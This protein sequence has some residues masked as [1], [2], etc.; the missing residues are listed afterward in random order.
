MD[1]AFEPVEL[2]L[3]DPFTIA[4][5]TQVLAETVHLT[6]TQDDSSGIGEA[7][8][9]PHYGELGSTVL[10][11]LAALNDRLA[12][13]DAPLSISAL[14]ALMD[15]VAMLNPAAKAAVD[16]A[17]YDLLGKR[18]G[19]PVYEILGLDP[20][21]AP[22]TSYTIG[23]DTP[24]VMA[25]K[26]VEAGSYPVLKV[27]VGT[28]NDEANLKAIRAERPDALIRVDANMAWKPKEAVEKIER[29]AEYDL[30][31]IEQPVHGHDLEGLGYVRSA[32]SL[33]VIADESCIAPSDVAKVAPYVDGINIKLMKCGGIYPAL[34]MIHIARGLGLSVMMGCMIESSLA[35]TAAAHLSPLI[36]YAD[37]DGHL[38]IDDD[39][40]RGVL[41]EDG[42]LVLGQSPGLGVEQAR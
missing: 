4:R 31:F 38:L 10:V 15:D 20:L 29:L 26:A 1:L 42:K 5:G 11:Y 7:A 30:E 13:V 2:Q 16:M 18:L 19:A 24:E 22:R 8:P 27:K 21:E 14:H 39:P 25:R 32:V 17:A 40:F 6:L 36:D 41:V 34:E 12:E 35:I 33:P 3:H 23:I 37:L 9:S 28:D